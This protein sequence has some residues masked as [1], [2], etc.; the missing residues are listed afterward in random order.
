MFRRR[1]QR[2]IIR[3]Q[4]ESSLSAQ[5]N[6]AETLISSGQP[7]QA[8]QLYAR[9]A[10]EAELTHH[11]RRAG[12]FYTRAAHAWL[13][14]QN[15]AQARV[16]ATKAVSYYNQLG[17][18]LRAQRFQE[19]FDLHLNS[20]QTENAPVST[21]SQ[22]PVQARQAKTLPTACPQ[23]GAPLRADEVEWAD[24]STAECDFCG[25]MIR[26]E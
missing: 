16:C 5:M 8:A 4:M 20:L 26:A 19:R 7:A 1:L 6:Q 3:P 2:R 18:L 24:E 13:D 14:G 12:S 25:A 9:L 11:P 21:S 17:M 23:C 10:N 22:P 15:I